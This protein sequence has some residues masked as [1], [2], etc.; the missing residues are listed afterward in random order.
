[1]VFPLAWGQHGS[2]LHQLTGDWKAQRWV[3]Q[4]WPPCTNSPLC[5]PPYLPSPWP[6]ALPW[7]CPEPWEFPGLLVVWMSFPWTRHIWLAKDSPGM[8][9]I[10]ET[11]TSSLTQGSWLSQIFLIWFSFCQHSP[12]WGGVRLVCFQTCFVQGK[13]KARGSPSGAAV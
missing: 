8:S 3:V 5:F 4:H 2:T 6:C 11:W 12:K 1:M 13:I 10:G 7:C 9:W